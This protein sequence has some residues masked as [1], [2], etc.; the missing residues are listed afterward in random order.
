M[1]IILNGLDKKLIDIKKK[2]VTKFDLL[3]KNKNPHT[4]PFA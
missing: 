1:R 3:Y 2:P 4:D